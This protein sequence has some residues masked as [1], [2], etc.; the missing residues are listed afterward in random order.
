MNGDY[1]RQ[2]RGKLRSPHNA[3]HLCHGRSI[4][5]V[6]RFGPCCICVLWLPCCGMIIQYYIKGRCCYFWTVIQRDME[7]WRPK[8]S[9]THDCQKRVVPFLPGTPPPP[10]ASC[11]RVP[12][13]HPPPT[14]VAPSSCSCVA[15]LV[16]LLSPRG[17]L[18]KWYR[19]G[20][21][22]ELDDWSSMN[23][24]D[25]DLLWFDCFSRRGICWQPFGGTA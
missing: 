8:T 9:C 16:S 18:E 3:W 22:G 2:T 24:S 25:S 7:H 10:R 17:G 14:P 20:V 11:R 1:P 15:P 23:S 21:R 5:H 13:P 19:Y 4:V 12:P 6:T